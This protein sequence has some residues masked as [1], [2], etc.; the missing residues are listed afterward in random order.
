MSQSREFLEALFSNKPDELYVLVWTLRGDQKHSRWFRDVKNAAAYVESLRGRNVYV[1][2]GLSPSDFGPD[3]RCKSEDVAGIVGLGVD[4]DMKSE[5]HSKGARPETIEQALSILPPE[6]VPSLI[7]ETGN[8]IQAWWLFREPFIFENEQERQD[9]AALASRWQVL[10]KYAAQKTGWAFEKLGD[11]ARVLRVPGT[12]NLKDADH[13]KDVLIRTSTDHRYNPSDFRDYLDDLG[14]PSPDEQAQATRVWADHFFDKP[15]V[16]TLS[17]TVADKTLSSWMQ[18]DARFQRTWN[19]EREEMNDPSQSGYD[20]ALA[21]FGVRRGLTDQQIVDMIVHNR[22]VYGAKQ[23]HSLDY[24]RRTISK[25]RKGLDSS[26]QGVAMGIA[27]PPP[28]ANVDEST[29]QVARGGSPDPNEKVKLCDQ[30]STIL[31]VNILRIEKLGGSEPTYFME[32]DCGCIEFSR[33][34]M[35]LSAK[36]VR[37]AIAARTGKLIRKFRTAE[38]DQI[39][40]MLLNACTEKE[41]TEDLEFKGAARIYLAQYLSENPPFTSVEHLIGANKFSP[42]IHRG[43][44]AISSTHLQTYLNRT[45]EQKLSVKRVAAM[46]AAIGGAAIRVR[47]HGFREQ[48]RWALPAGDWPPE[49]YSP[50]YVGA[51]G[52]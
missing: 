43:S 40:Q 44:V 33:V 30:L 22:R 2:I 46:V 10:L 13:P 38:W 16:I 47:E 39:A 31:G 34:G 18:H 49:E 21:N 29:A 11:L 50:E 32:L 35:L 4:I 17:A 48:S 26:P 6:F 5:A 12:Q 15:L 19:H 3:N 36:V 23:S 42:L 37:E 24:F 8:G 1:G 45:Q 7:V 9:G 20:Q 41:A 52:V 14:I 28:S 51:A 25:A 27:L